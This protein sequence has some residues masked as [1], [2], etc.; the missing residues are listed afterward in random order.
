MDLSAHRRLLA[1]AFA[2]PAVIASAN[3][4]VATVNHEGWPEALRIT[5]GEVELVVVPAVGRIMHYGWAGGE[6]LLWQHPKRAGHR[7]LT[8]EGTWANVGGDKIWPWPD[9]SWPAATGDTLRD[10]DPPTE[11][12]HDPHSVEVTGPF[13]VR[14]TSPLWPAQGLRV[15][16]DIALAEVGTRLTLTTR[17]ERLAPPLASTSYADAIVEIVPWSVTQLAPPAAV[18][19]DYV[20]GS[21]RPYGLLLGASWDTAFDIDRHT[22]WLPS[23][24]GRSKIGVTG[25]AL[26]WWRGDVLLVQHLLGDEPDSRWAAYEQAQVFWTETPGDG[27]TPYVELEFTAPRRA[28]APSAP[29]LTVAW[30][31][32]RLRSQ[33]PTMD[34]V[35]A[36]FR[37]ASPAP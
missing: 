21:P 13:S 7:G 35:V 33:R 9:A 1:F 11:W 27:A 20:P 37:A 34:E 22:L 31:L 6:N 14:M 12:E 3:A 25:R 8:R 10:L 16:R 4:E 19:V 23:P 18:I 5:N 17:F 36:T 24:Q 32:H 26:G 15:V 28:D 29:T 30:E 2:L